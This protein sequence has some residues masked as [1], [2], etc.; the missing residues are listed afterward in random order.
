MDPEKEQ[1]F[2][3]AVDA[4]AVADVLNK[5]WDPERV[6]EWPPTPDAPQVASGNPFLD[7]T[8]RGYYGWGMGN[9]CAAI[10]Q[11]STAEPE[12]VTSGLDL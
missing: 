3:G 7:D 12:I 2:F 9:S 11:V 5:K 4:G 6:A 1:R 10:E 8:D